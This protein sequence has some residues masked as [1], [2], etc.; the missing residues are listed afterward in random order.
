MWRCSHRL[1]A[2]HLVICGALERH[3]KL[4]VIVPARCYRC[5][6]IGSTCCCPFWPSPAHRCH[7]DARRAT[8][9]LLRPGRRS[10]TR[11]ARRV[12]GADVSRD[13]A[14][15]LPVWSATSI[16]RSMASKV[17]PRSYASRSPKRAGLSLCHVAD[18]GK[19]CMPR[20]ASKEWWLSASTRLEGFR[21]VPDRRPWEKL[22]RP[23]P[24]AIGG[25]PRFRN[26]GSRF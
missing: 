19:E 11:A 15:A 14:T 4:K 3:Y 23:E 25:P 2:R 13:L 9:A 16:N 21:G 5:S 8:P 1:G 12:N 7:R 17:Q 18:A 10:D 22:N 20:R 26:R 24:V 6:P